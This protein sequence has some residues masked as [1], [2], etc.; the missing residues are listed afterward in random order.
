MLIATSITFLYMKI[1]NSIAACSTIFLISC[2]GQTGDSATDNSARQSGLATT[3]GTVQAST[4]VDAEG[5]AAASASLATKTMATTTAVVADP[6]T[7]TQVTFDATNVYYRVPYASVPN[8]VRVF[9][10]S[11]SNAGTGFPKNGIG[12][13]YLIENGQLYRYSGS[14]GAWAWTWVKTVGFNRGTTYATVT[15]PRADLGSVSALDSV[16]ES[17]PPLKISSKI[18]TSFASTTSTPTTTTTT[19]PT[20]TTTTTPT[21][22]PTTTTT[23]P[24]TTTTTPTTTTTAPTTTTTPTTT[25]APTTTTSTVTTTVRVD[26]FGDSTVWG[27]IGGTSYQV[28]QTPPMVLD[29]NLPANYAVKNEGVGGASIVELLEGRDGV[30]PTWATAVT[31]TTAK[32]IIMN[33]GINDSYERDTTTT[34]Y[35]ANYA[36]AI[37]IARAAGKIII[38]ETPN[39][40]HD[41]ALTASFADAM[42][43]VAAEKGVPV[44]D[45][46][47]YLKQYMTANNL[48]I[49]Q[50]TNDGVHPTQATYTLK[51][52]YAA[53]RFKEIVGIQ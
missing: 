48:G 19:T 13:N 38:L 15:A 16:T 33:Y 43:Q 27:G 28:A 9:V 50:V 51:G 8:W 7:V 42:K 41:G 36:K 5:T 1:I 35:K 17:D 31:Q 10:D 47:Y 20:T 6:S 37:D 29:A 49:Y 34:S 23:T 3:A 11:D 53:K 26:Y 18:S 12:A 52:Q 30:H 45:Q 46:Y 44:I 40:T 4:G 32:Y 22:T 25:T 39:P 24:T 2:G 21:T 14:G